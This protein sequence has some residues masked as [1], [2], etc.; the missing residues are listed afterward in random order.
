MKTALLLI[1][2][3]N[4]YFPGGAMELVDSQLAAKQAK[5]LLEHFRAAKQ[6]IWHIQHI[7]TRPDA[8]FFLP[9]TEGA[10]IHAIVAPLPG[11]PVIVKHFP[12]AFY[13][14]NLLDDLRTQSVER[15][16]ICGMMTHMCIDTT[17]RAAKDAGFGCVI[18]SSACAT[19]DLS[20]AGKTVAA[21]DVQT[22]FLSALSY[23][24][25]EVTP[26]ADVLTLL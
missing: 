3:Q 26:A 15:L 16:V 22:A 24:F 11:E 5:A 2:I 4:D 17:V 9:N 1:D 10:A 20:F 23:Y 6:P 12:N 13:Q 7:A 14:T 8:T 25:A 21:A 18:A 19:K